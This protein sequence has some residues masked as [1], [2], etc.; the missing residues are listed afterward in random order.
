[1]KLHAISDLDNIVTVNRNKK[2]VK[3]HHNDIHVGDIIK[4]K[5]GMNIPVDGV[6]VKGSGIMTNE[7]AMTGEP[8]EL[9]KDTLEGCKNRKEEKDQEFLLSKNPVKKPQDL[10]S[11]VLLS[12]TQI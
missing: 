9:P 1:M 5:A 4:I 8:N 12:G 7:S 2:Q 10:P 3:V 6:V 11:P